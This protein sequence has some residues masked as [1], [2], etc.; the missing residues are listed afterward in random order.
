MNSQADFSENYQE[1]LRCHQRGDLT[2][3]QSLYERALL[4]RP[5]D[6]ESLHMLGACLIQQGKSEAGLP[7]IEKALVI[8]P[9]SHQA[10]FNRGN[11]LYALGDYP[12]ALSSFQRAIDLCPQDPEYHFEKA[13]SLKALR[14]PQHALAA[15]RQAIALKPNYIQAIYQ[16]ALIMQELKQFDDALSA[17]GTLISINPRLKPALLAKAD[18]LAKIGRHEQALEA[19]TQFATAFPTDENAFLG[20]AICLRKLGR[21]EESAACLDDARSRLATS[22]TFNYQAAALT[23][24]T[25]VKA[26]RDYVQS[27]FDSYAGGFE[28]HLVEDL[29]YTSPVMMFQ[30]FKS[31]F[32]ESN[33]EC[34]DLGCGTGLGVIAYRERIRSATGVDLS[35]RMLEQ[36]KARNLYDKLV[37]ADIADYLE[38]TED[39]FDLVLAFDVFIYVGDLQRIFQGVRRVLRDNGLF[40]FTVE[41]AAERKV[42]LKASARFGHKKD[43][44]LAL[45]NEHG[46]LIESFEEGTI[47]KEADTAIAGYLVH[48]RS[49]RKPEQAN[50]SHDAQ[51]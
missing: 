17:Y 13:N 32:S 44:L 29:G 16:G 5:D 26:P 1:A 14:K 39:R 37:S 49:V 7:C 35:E 30:H 42:E 51:Q 9:D 6:F 11:G 21:L 23:G 40:A 46:F 48:L 10:H 18:L 31:R 4:A 22:P 2:K 3:A 45:A 25:L 34:L 24:E 19:F 20:K 41:S 47:R 36:A 43:Y 27:L 15:Y 50:A 12:A 38:T 33:L 8:R 28:K